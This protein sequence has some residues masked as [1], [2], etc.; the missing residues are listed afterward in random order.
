MQCTTGGARPGDQ[1]LPAV[2]QIS[3]SQPQIGEVTPKRVPSET[4][5]LGDLSQPHWDRS[6]CLC[7]FQDN[8]MSSFSAYSLLLYTNDAFQGGETTFFAPDPLLPV[9]NKKLTPQCDRTKLKVAYQVHP[10][11]GDALVFPH[12]LHPGCG[13]PEFFFLKSLL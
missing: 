3:V 12:G 11:A 1:L 2:L 6:Y 9:S 10:K 5:R 7:E 8:V 13:S 4:L